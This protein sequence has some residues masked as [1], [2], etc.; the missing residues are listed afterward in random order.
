VPAA[1]KKAAKSS[2]ITEEYELKHQLIE[3][4]L[5]LVDG[6]RHTPPKAKEKTRDKSPCS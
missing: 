4:V 3:E 2:D 5:Q 6:H 1:T